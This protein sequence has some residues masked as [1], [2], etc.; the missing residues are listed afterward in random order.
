MVGS[1]TGRRKSKDPEAG[2]CLLNLRNSKEA[3]VV[4]VQGAVG[5]EQ[6]TTKSLV[7]Q[8]NLRTSESLLFVPRR[9]W[10]VVSGGR[11]DSGCISKGSLQLGGP[12]KITQNGISS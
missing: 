10:K 3:S 2:V 4:E 1:I 6:S 12:L 5:I 7:N 9:H 8:G 11:I